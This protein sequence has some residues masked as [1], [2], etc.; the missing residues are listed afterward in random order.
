MKIQGAIIL[1]G[2]VNTLSI[3]RG[4]IN[5]GLDVVILN[6]DKLAL[7]NYSK[8]VKFIKSPSIN[9]QRAFLNFLY[10]LPQ[11]YLEKTYVLI[12]TSDEEV[13]LLSEKKDLLEEMFIVLVDKKDTIRIIQN[14]EKC[15]CFVRSL[16]IYVPKFIVVKSKN[17][18]LQKTKHL[19]FPLIIKTKFPHEHKFKKIKAIV[20]NSRK[21]LSVVAK[22]P[23]ELLREGVLIQELIPHSEHNQISFCSY[24][25]KG[26]ILKYFMTKKIRSRPKDYGSFTIVE[27][28][29]SE[30]IYKLSIKILAT[31]NY[32]GISE[33]EFIF[34]ERT[35][36]F[37]FIELNP[38]FWMQ[39]GLTQKIGIDL[40]EPIINFEKIVSKRSKFQNYELGVKWI[41]IYSDLYQ[42]LNEIKA[43]KFSIKDFF[44]GWKGKKHFAVL[45]IND[46]VPFII[47][48]YQALRKLFEELK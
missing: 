46:P 23:K 35:N 36:K 17:E 25:F 16:G 40:I 13:K 27:S 10:K 38:R 9:D 30:P 19:N 48:S 14:K 6:D 47:E 8:R 41:H 43:K 11:R 7:A 44:K 39:N 15:F 5:K 24:S 31:L 33:I 21:C 22:L 18:M 42:T 37:N 1:G 45:S 2:Y 4:F 29:Y 28:A 3:A 32:T 20:N 26:K 12:P 34:D